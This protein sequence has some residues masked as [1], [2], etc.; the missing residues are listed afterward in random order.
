MVPLTVVPGGGVSAVLAVSSLG[1]AVLAVPVAVAGP[2]M[3][4]SPEA[5]LA[6]GTMPPCGPGHTL[7][8]T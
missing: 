4:E 3:W 6:V 1:V 8:L 2:A 5:W 7:T